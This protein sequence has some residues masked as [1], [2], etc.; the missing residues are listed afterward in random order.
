MATTPRD[1]YHILGVP[2]TASSDDIKKAFRRLAR[3]YHPDL[4]AGAKK[5]E[6][7]KKFKVSLPMQILWFYGCCD[8]YLIPSLQLEIYGLEK[9]VMNGNR[10]MEFAVVNNKHKIGFNTK[11]INT[12]NEWDIININTNLLLASTISKFWSANLF[13]WVEN[14]QP[15]WE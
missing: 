8:G 4:H 9:L 1:Y 3:Q 12:A 15:L 5:A 11:I 6:M 7:E 14:K 13:N 10:I 2:R